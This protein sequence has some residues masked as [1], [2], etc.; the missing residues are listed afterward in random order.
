MVTMSLTLR[1]LSNLSFVTR[2]ERKDNT[3]LVY[4]VLV[5]LSVLEGFLYGWVRFTN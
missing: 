2:N 1:R 4:E 3:A 5:N